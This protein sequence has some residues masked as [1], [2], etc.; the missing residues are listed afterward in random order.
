MRLKNGNHFLAVNAFTRK[1]IGKSAGDTVQLLLFEDNSSLEIPPE[2]IVCLQ[3]EPIAHERF[4]KLAPGYQKEFI[5]WIYAAK[6]EATKAS[7]IAG[8]I[9]KLIKGETLSKVKIK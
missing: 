7:R 1:S 4:M 2:L 9:D 8:M 5:S 6:Q 3:D